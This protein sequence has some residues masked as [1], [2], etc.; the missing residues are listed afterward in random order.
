[1]QS[2]SIAPND[3][4]A[5]EL[6]L[7]GHDI[8]AAV[9]DILAGLALIDDSALPARDR[10]QLD[11]TRANSEGLI[12]LL[13]E[14][15]T[16]L[17]THAPT[18]LPRSTVDLADLVGD[19]LRRWGYS[20]QGQVTATVTT[21]ANL[22]PRFSCN[23]TAVERVL[24]NLLSNAISHSGGRPV[25]LD[26]THPTAQ[27]LCFTIRDHG[28]GFP[29]S[30]TG[31]PPAAERSALPHWKSAHGHGLGLRI[32]QNLSQRMGAEVTLHNTDTQGGI[33]T[34]RLPI[35]VS[36]NPPLH[37]VTSRSLSGQRVLVADDSA[38]Q[39]LLLGQILVESGAEVTLV[40]DGNAA[41]SALQ[42]GRFDLAVLD[43]EMP[44][45]NGLDLCKDLRALSQRPRIA[46]F[47]AHN[48]P[49]ILE[50]ARAAGAD[51]VLV[52]PITSAPELVAA[53][54]APAPEAAAFAHLLDM[55]G[56]DMANTLIAQFQNDLRDVQIKLTAAFDEPDWATLRG[57]SHVLIA[58]AG[59]AGALALEAAARCLN[60]CANDNDSSGLDEHGPSVQ[61]G[62]ASLLRF[63]D[64]TA[65]E[66]LVRA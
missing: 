43:M 35:A 20:A 38:T 54:C 1:M 3:P 5:E 8:R 26:I 66:R 64:Q 57:A 56:A 21:A 22:P 27:E 61:H 31:K 2:E 46:I 29:A 51:M 40:R 48:Q 53:L 63:M 10:Q 16:T 36:E 28:P 14:G 47:T 12:R 13:D 37:P 59:T 7:L 39:L 15:L 49:E 42:E 18:D 62:L 33:A 6:A 50:K 4:M 19:I 55:A 52:K 11:R 44:G 23:R 34:F 60:Q 24:A 30:L 25:T 9:T 41:L 45:R 17:L 32:A 65:T 58:L